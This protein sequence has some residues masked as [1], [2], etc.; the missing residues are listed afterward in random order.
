M[1][2]AQDMGPAQM[3]IVRHSDPQGVQILRHHLSLGSRG[4]P[5][6]VGNESQETLEKRVKRAKGVP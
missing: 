6:A 2:S 5:G 3:T 1:V 4:Y